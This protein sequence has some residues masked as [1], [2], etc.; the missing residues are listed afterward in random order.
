LNR[1][2]PMLPDQYHR[3][4]LVDEVMRF[5]VTRQE[6]VY[7][8]ATLG[9]GGH[10]RALAARLSSR[11]VIVG[12]DRDAEALTYNRGQLPEQVTMIREN[13]RNI[14]RA[15]RQCG[16]TAADGILFDLGVS[17]WQ[18]DNTRRG[19]AYQSDQ[20]LDMRMDDRQELTAAAVLNSYP[21]ERLRAVFDNYGEIR[22]ARRLAAAVERN[23][24]VTTSAELVW[25]VR[26]LVGT[27][28][29]N[30]LL[31][32]IFQSLRI[33]VNQELEALQTGVERA[34]D[35]LRPGGR[36][37]VIAYH[38][39]EDR[40]V[41]RYFRDQAKGCSCPPGIVAC[42]CGKVPRLDILTPKPV[43]PSAKEQHINPRSR[44]AKL[45]AAQKRG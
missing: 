43:Q 42:R 39:L 7:I 25:I 15:A 13:F 33:E 30:K 4:V 19:F 45:R 24:P 14:D 5:L 29:I 21:A 11:A 20:A 9:G 17:S 26:S 38:S 31:S 22:W 34:L 41:K 6:G 27:K 16:L 44:S 40:I 28:P 18:L 1:A 3:P 23:R 32:R 12:L 10:T 37:V 36:L 8:D 2:V 35:L